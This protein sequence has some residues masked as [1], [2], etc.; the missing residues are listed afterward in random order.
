MA[1]TLNYKCDF[2]EGFF[3]CD[4]P[5][6]SIQLKIKTKLGQH[7]LTVDHERWIEKYTPWEKHT[8]SSPRK[9]L[10]SLSPKK[11]TDTSMTSDSGPWLPPLS[12]NIDQTFL[13]MPGTQV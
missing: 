4:I 1:R 13:M 5:K 6:D 12:L 7:T 11:I 8:K 3:A 10:E 9:R 2:D